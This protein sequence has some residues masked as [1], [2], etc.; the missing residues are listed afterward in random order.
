MIR[1]LT[2]EELKMVAFGGPPELDD[3]IILSVILDSSGRVAG[4]IRG[5]D[6]SGFGNP[7]G[8]DMSA[9]GGDDG[10]DDSSEDNSGPDGADYISTCSSLSFIPGVP[11]AIGQ[12]ISTACFLS[13]P[14]IA[15]AYNIM[16]L[17]GLINAH[18][19]ATGGD[20]LMLND[21]RAML[22]RGEYAEL[23]DIMRDTWE[24]KPKK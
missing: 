7:G 14:E 15:E 17:H 1:E 21:M 4:F 11:P 9:G 2:D 24:E 20:A 23:R 6:G 19:S 3:G 10:N 16:E 13:N 12:F 5:G 22:S 18:F 8:L